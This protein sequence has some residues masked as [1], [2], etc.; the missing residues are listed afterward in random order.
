MRL[1]VYDVMMRAYFR[2]HWL[3]DWW[4]RLAFRIAP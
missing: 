4:Q 3:G 2:I 1:R